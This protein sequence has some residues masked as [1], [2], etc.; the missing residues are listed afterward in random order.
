MPISGS[1][2]PPDPLSAF[3]CPTEPGGR[4]NSVG[5][6]AWVISALAWVTRWLVQRRGDGVSGRDMV[7]LGVQVGLCRRG[8][9]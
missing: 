8:R 7:I 6:S 9:R 5:E 4:R 1:S 3:N 2:S